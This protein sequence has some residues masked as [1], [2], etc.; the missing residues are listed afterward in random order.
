MSVILHLGKLLPAGALGLNMFNHQWKFQVGYVF[1][2]PALIP[3][4]LSKFL[5]EHVHKIIQTSY[6]GGIILDGCSLASHS[7]QHVTGCHVPIC[8]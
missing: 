6:S 2:P 7:S 4:V 5:V 3:L 1:L 8:S